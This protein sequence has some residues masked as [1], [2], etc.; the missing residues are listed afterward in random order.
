M[1]LRIL[2][3]HRI[4]AE[5]GQAVHVRE[6]IGALRR[7]GHEVL[8]CALVQKAV[9]MAASDAPATSSAGFWRRLSL[10]RSVVE[11]LEVAY[12]FQGRRMLRAAAAAFR[13]DV[14][15]ERHALH[16]RVGLDVARQTG[17]P[18]LLEVNSPMTD[19]MRDL[20]LLRLPRRALQT[21]R[22]TLAGADRVLAVTQALGDRLVEL[23]AA[24]ERLR[25]VHNGVDVE[26]FGPKAKAQAAAMRQELGLAAGA[27]VLG[28]IGYA[29]PWHRLDLVVDLMTRPGFGDL[30]LWVAGSGPALPSLVAQATRLGTLDRCHF[31]GAVPASA[32]PAHA[33]AFDVALIPAINAYA[34]P[35]K[36]FDSLA[37]GVPTIAPDQPNLREV[38]EHGRTAALYRPGD[39]ED[40]GA[41]LRMLM[42]DAALRR[43]I[44]E[45]GRKLV[46]EG[47]YTWADNAA[48]IEAIAREA[49]A[50]RKQR[51][52]AA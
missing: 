8:E 22:L 28:F 15:Y 31:L 26:R 39:G 42:D 19:E 49:I 41:K 14:I 50:E 51:G 24:R 17:V 13:P 40:L 29:R 30:H 5:D 23:G 7:A 9:P 20:G 43:R 11:R 44:G 21:E 2:Y 25:I 32:V 16:C 35:L 1:S 46:G 37:A 48:R 47:G 18:L 12:N 10:P 6:V 52:G 3:H 33:C 38:V 34:S 36:L 4:R 45:A 27:F